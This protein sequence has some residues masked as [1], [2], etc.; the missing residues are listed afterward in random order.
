MV[1]N[2]VNDTKAAEEVV[3]EIRSH[4]KGGAIAVK[5]DA[6]TTEGGKLILD[7]AKKTFGRVDI[8]ILNMGI[9][10]DMTLENLNEATFNAQVQINVKAPLFLA[11]E[12]MP[13]LPSRTSSMLNANGI[14]QSLP[15]KQLAAELSSFRQR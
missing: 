14:V 5:A 1:V 13:L 2:Y 8:L 15:G 10:E 7:E 3:K 9:M 4:G 6:S 12:A 11:K